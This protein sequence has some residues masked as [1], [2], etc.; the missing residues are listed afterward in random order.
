MFYE[1]MKT[2]AIV[3]II[4]GLIL[5]P[6]KD[7]IT[8]DNAAK[9]FRN[10]KLITRISYLGVAMMW[11]QMNDYFHAP[12]AARL[13]VPA[14]WYVM[15][16]LA[17]LLIYVAFP[18]FRVWL[19]VA[20]ILIAGWCAHIYVTFKYDFWSFYFIDSFK[21][22]LNVIAQGLICCTILAACVGILYFIGPY[23]IKRQIHKKT[24]EDKQQ[25]TA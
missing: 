13:H 5:I 21:D 14:V 4:A 7:K 3:I 1:D 8:M 2:L 20:A 18:V 6:F 15:I 24:Y 25:N 19:V 9:L 23:N 12:D 17:A 10:K 16:P 22:V 11:L